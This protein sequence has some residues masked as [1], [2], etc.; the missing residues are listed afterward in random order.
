M[1]LVISAVLFIA[2]LH[3]DFVFPWLEHT[4]DSEGFSFSNDNL[5]DELALSGVIVS[6]LLLAFS[7]ERIEDEYVRTIRLKC[8]QWAVM[9]NYALLLVGIWLVYGTA[10]IAILYYNMLTTLVLFLVLFYGKLYLFP[11]IA[12]KPA[13]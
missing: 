5:T 7:A 3:Y 6:L 12:K 10:F 9:V 11:M 8:W 1:L 4:A 2:T 13:L